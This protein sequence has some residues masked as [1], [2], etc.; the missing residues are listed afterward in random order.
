[1]KLILAIVSDADKN[2]VNWALIENE[3]QSTLVSSSGGLLE[4]GYVTF[5]I[6]TDDEKVEE[7]IE[8]IKS[9]VS[10]RREI[11]KSKLPPTLQSLFFVKKE[12][13]EQGG[14]VFFIL[15]IEKM[16]KV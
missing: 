14:A 1:M 9:N 8:L 11:P 4:K 7:I 13:I 15:D 12:K 3:I 5:L 10:G 16:E 6:G 2:K